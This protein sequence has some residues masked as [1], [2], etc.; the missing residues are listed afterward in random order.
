MENVKQTNELSELTLR[1][2]LARIRLE[3]TNSNIKKSGENKYAGFKYFELCDIVPK[4]L[5]L[6][7]K[8]DVTFDFSMS[9]DF[10]N[11]ALYD[12]VKNYDPIVFK[13]P[14][15]GIDDPKAMRMNAVQAMGSEITYYRRYMYNIVLD[16]VENDSID[17]LDNTQKN[18]AQNKA[19][20]SPNKAKANTTNNVP[21]LTQEQ[22]NT[23]KNAVKTLLEKDPRY[24]VKM[25]SL[26]ATSYGFTEMTEKS[27]NDTLTRIN[28]LLDGF[29]AEQK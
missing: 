9:D 23:I 28:K 7:A 10:V 20:T 8:Y 4:A 11:G 12:N 13:F 5:E 26:E 16:I 1:Q 22:T 6:F 14:K 2:K 15:K 3:F 19:K 25:D 17:C 21:K 29:I 24:K 27:Y 18:N